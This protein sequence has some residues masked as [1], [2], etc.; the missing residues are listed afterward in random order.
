LVVFLVIARLPAHKSFEITHE[1]VFV[2]EDRN[3]R[4]TFNSSHLVESTVLIFVV[5]RSWG[6]NNPRIREEKKKS[7]FRRLRTTDGYVRSKVTQFTVFPNPLA[8]EQDM[9]R[10]TNAKFERCF[11]FIKH[12]KGSNKSTNWMQQFLKFIIW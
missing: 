3:Y 2:E 10:P 12:T 11:E 7:Y 5:E 8:E 9:S 6:R 4:T 1:D